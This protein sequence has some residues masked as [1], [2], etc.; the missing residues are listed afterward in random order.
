[1]ATVEI[2]EQRRHVHDMWAAVAPRWADYADDVDERGAAMTDRLL[3][4]AG[5]GPGDDVLELASGPGGAGLAAAAAVGQQGHVVIS[6]V[7][8]EMAA[9]AAARART[10]GL[11]NVT[12]A[13]LDLEAIDRPGAT[14]DVVVCREGLMFAVDPASALHEIHR[15]L[16][17][18]GRLALS[19]WGPRQAN[20]WLGVVIGAVAAVTGM[21][22]PPPGMPGPFALADR[23]ALVALVESARF[24]DVTAEAL[25]VP[26]RSPSFDAWW[27]RTAAVAG[28]V[29]AIIGRLD[30]TK[31]AEMEDNLRNAVAEYT[32]DAGVEFPGLALLVCAR[33]S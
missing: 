13:T 1:M 24:E 8:P 12:T 6:D 4:G 10:R 22:V 5:I 32:T 29:A 2:A 33:G 19:V 11:R 30:A 15:V 17:P 7:V 31:R 9:I 25:A 14:F 26:L 21:L 18:G 3:A 20:P 28:P 23:D 16:R 27:A